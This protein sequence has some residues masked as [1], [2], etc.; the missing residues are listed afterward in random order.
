MLEAPGSCLCPDSSCICRIVLAM[1]PG[2]QQLW[3]LLTAEQCGVSHEEA[4]KRECT[5]EFI[6]AIVDILGRCPELECFCSMWIALTRARYLCLDE[7]VTAE[8]LGCK[9]VVPC[10]D[11]RLVKEISSAR[12]EQLA[13][14]HSIAYGFVESLMYRDHLADDTKVLIGQVLQILDEL[15]VPLLQKDSWVCR[16]HADVR[17]RFC[18]RKI[19]VTSHCVRCEAC[20]NDCI[21]QRWSA[22]VTVWLREH[23]CVTRRWSASSAQKMDAYMYIWIWHHLVTNCGKRQTQKQP[24]LH[25]KMIYYMSVCK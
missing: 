23:I 25:N 3:L 16:C 7:S 15:T 9:K 2:F 19:V 11:Y 14:E 8:G 24:N 4:D 12:K 20:R 10:A 5:R 13:L 6:R 17:R 21:R 22:S 18:L 1:G